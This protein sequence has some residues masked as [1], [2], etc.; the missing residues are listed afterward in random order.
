MRQQSRQEALVA[1]ALECREAASGNPNPN[2]TFGG[3]QSFQRIICGLT[4]GGRKKRVKIQDCPKR[5]RVLFTLSAPFLLRALEIQYVLPLPYSRE[6][7][8]L[9]SREMRRIRIERPSLETV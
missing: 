5:E 3:S 8:L 7:L 6:L 2:P 4:G 9:R 1:G